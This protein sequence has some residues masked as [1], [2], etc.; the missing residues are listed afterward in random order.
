MAATL[1]ERL[2]RIPDWLRQDL[3]SS[4]P[5]AR[6]RVAETLAAMLVLA[7]QKPAGPPVDRS[8]C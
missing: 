4:D 3:A 8:S 2:R 7:F 1:N 5:V 6:E